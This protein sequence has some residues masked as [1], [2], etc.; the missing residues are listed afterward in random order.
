L[1][2]RGKIMYE[3]AKPFKLSTTNDLL[4]I[5]IYIIKDYIE[6]TTHELTLKTTRIRLRKMKRM[7]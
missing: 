1:K 7:K 2:E 4:G 5:D 3:G 6:V